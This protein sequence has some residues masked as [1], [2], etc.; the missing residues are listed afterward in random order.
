MVLAPVTATRA[1]V[2]NLSR[3]RESMRI[4]SLVIDK[5]RRFSSLRIEGLKQEN[6]LVILAGPNGNGKSSLFDAIHLWSQLNGGTGWGGDGN[7]YFKDK[8]SENS[9]IT[10]L[11]N[12]SVFPPSNPKRKNAFYFRTAYRNDTEFELNSL[13]TQGPV[14]DSLRFYRMI[15]NDTTVSSNY[16]RLASQAMADLFEKTAGNTTVDQFRESIISELRGA[17]LNLFPHLTLESLG[18]PL[19]RG[20]FRFTKGSVSN[21]EYKKLSGGEKAAFDVLLDLIVKKNTY[22]DAIYCIDE[23]EAHL[24]SRLHGEFLK[25]IFALIPQESQLWISTHSIGMMR[26][27]LDLYKQDPNSVCFFDFAGH[28]F[29][30][31]VL[32]QPEKPTRAFWERALDVALDDLAKLVVPER[33]II[34]EGNPAGAVAG[35]NANHDAD[36]LNAIF[37]GTH[38]ETKF[39]AGGNSH[40]VASDRLGFA[41]AFPKIAA[42]INVSRLIDL[43]DHAP[44][45]VAKFKAQG[46]S[47]LGRRHIESY[48]FGDDILIALC[49]TVDLS[50]C[51][52]PVLADKQA[53]LASISQQGKPIDDVKSAAGV[54]YTKLKQRLSLSQVGSDQRAFARNI[55]VPLITPETQTYQ[56]LETAIFS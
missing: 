43:D 26:T 20:T 53:A 6:R 28:D 39:I 5:F 56:E 11:V 55:L 25:T 29:D 23:P 50:T 22:S 13:Q 12:L 1:H 17:I 38:P 7:Y 44:A 30:Q 49:D 3:D 4:S 14:E 8:K 36:C 32:L 19:E 52:T 18:N 10:T 40:D 33:V 16:Q 48:L 47:V 35:K 42:G 54:I 34:C 24:N 41:A 31:P 15:D 37:S 9:K 45:D 51:A 46:I 21:F 27:A 2:G